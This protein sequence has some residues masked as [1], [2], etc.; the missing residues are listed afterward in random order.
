MSEHQFKGVYNRIYNLGYG[1]GRHE[2]MKD[3]AKSNSIWF[4][5]GIALGLLMGIAMHLASRGGV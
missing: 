1:D 5:G 2:A 3:V 4:A